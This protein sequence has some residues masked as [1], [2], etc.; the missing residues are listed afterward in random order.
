MLGPLW[1]RCITRMS[2]LE[3]HQVTPNQAFVQDVFNVFMTGAAPGIDVESTTQ[4]LQQIQHVQVT[5][6]AVLLGFLGAVHWGM[7]FAKYGGEQG[8]CIVQSRLTSALR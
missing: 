4:F 6:G 7:E 8:M 1:R 2:S 3:L 5:Y